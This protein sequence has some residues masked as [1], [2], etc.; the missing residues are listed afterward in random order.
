MKRLLAI[1]MV[2]VLG[3]CVNDGAGTSTPGGPVAAGNFAGA[4]R[5]VPKPGLVA[6]VIV[7]ER[8]KFYKLANTVR[9]DLANR[10]VSGLTYFAKKRCIVWVRADLSP[11][12]FRL[13]LAHELRHCESGHY[14]T[15]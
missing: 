7:M 2:V 9:P 5:W 10:P 6:T 8:E 14:H 15:D 3:G 1:A 13:T 12:D 11:T 4:E